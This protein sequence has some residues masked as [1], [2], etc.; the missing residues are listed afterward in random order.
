MSA[1]RLLVA[2]AGTGKTHSL[3]EEILAAARARGAAFDLR[4]VLAV[5]FT[6]AAA[7]ELRL[8]IKGEMLRQGLAEQA[9]QADT[10]PIMTFHA[11]C[12]RLL[13]EQAFERG[14]SPEPVTLD[15]QAARFLMRHSIEAA[16]QEQPRLEEEWEFLLDSM[17]EFD[18]FTRRTAE[19]QVLD[20]VGHLIEAARS[21]RKPPETFPEM[22]ERAVAA[23]VLP[24]PE[25]G[26]EEALRQAC[27]RFAQVWGRWR[28]DSRAARERHDKVLRAHAL[29][30]AGRALPWRDWRALAAL[31]AP[32]RD[33]PYNQA[34]RA[35]QEVAGRLR[36]HPGYQQ[37]LHRTIRALGRLA[38]AAC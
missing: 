28:P 19:Q 37:D 3:V 5:T 22:A 15:E 14:A 23:L 24:P 27:S 2:G 20:H 4:R 8:R 18:F 9:R 13:A 1:L 38:R 34:L 29:L 31:E 16:L 36:C 30:Q 7:A 6:E 21:L 32:G 35:V 25:E 26:L 11:F 10:A 12:L 33:N 17:Y